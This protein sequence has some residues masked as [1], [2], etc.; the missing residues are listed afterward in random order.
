MLGH[1]AVKSLE[2]ISKLKKLRALDM[3]GLAVT[4][5]NEL[6][7]C[8][9]T[10]AAENGGM[11]LKTDN[12]KIEDFSFLSA[13][14][15]IAWAE[16]ADISPDKW[17]DAASQ[18]KIHGIYCNGFNQEQLVRFLEEH[19]EI[20]ELHIPYCE[21]VTDLSMLPGMENLQYVKISQNMKKAV[22]SLEGLEYSFQLQID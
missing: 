9:F 2:G 7:Q 4:D 17:L 15:G 1:T 19:P 20:S 5:L 3:N 8:D 22:K 11:D 12:R 21:K 6:G 10:Y 14:P 16:F 18:T 13:I